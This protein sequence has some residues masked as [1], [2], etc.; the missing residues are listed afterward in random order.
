MALDQ[1]VDDLLDRLVCYADKGLNALDSARNEIRQLEARNAELEGR[2]VQLE[3]RIN[4]LRSRLTQAIQ[5]PADA[6]LLSRPDALMLMIRETLGLK[7]DPVAS[8]GDS[9]ND[10][11][12]NAL[13]PQ[14]RLQHWIKTYPKAFMPGQPQPLKVGIHE[15]ILAAE[16]G[17]MKKIRR[18]LAGYVKVPR[19]LRCMKA[20]AV[21]LDLTGR[22]AGFVTAEEAGFAQQQL[23][24]LEQQ[25]KQQEEHRN[26]HLLQQQQQEEEQRI[27]NKLSE[28]MQRHTT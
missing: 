1:G 25:K 26:Q 7:V 9:Q 3:G 4:S 20:G 2:V 28:L 17:E 24:S 21:R 8:A 23:D 18:A 22:N 5:N 27:K 6:A 10:P 19:Y 13:N 11:A 12:V 15:D 16:G 14:Q